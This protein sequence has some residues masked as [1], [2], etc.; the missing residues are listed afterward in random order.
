MKKREQIQ[1][2]MYSKFYFKFGDLPSEYVYDIITI[3]LNEK[4]IQEIWY[5]IRGELFDVVFGERSKALK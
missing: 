3:Q 1:S 4:L 5:P 2:N